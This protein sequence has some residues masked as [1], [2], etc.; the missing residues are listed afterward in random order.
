MLE[1]ENHPED[2]IQYKPSST[3]TLWKM[4]SDCL[5][6]VGRSIEEPSTGCQIEVV[7]VPRSQV[8]LVHKSTSFT[9][10]PEGRGPSLVET[11]L[12]STDVIRGN[13]VLLPSTVNL[14]LFCYVFV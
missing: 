11:R 3:A 8:S 12:L 10:S 2:Q 6:G 5:E 9:R 4:N 1:K 14:Y 13:K 7:E